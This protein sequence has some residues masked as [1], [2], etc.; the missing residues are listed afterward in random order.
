MGQQV[1]AEV[2]WTDGER[3]VSTG[4]SGN[5]MM[6]DADRTRN[7]APGP[8]ELVLIAL[9]ACTASDVLSILRKKR[10]S[11]NS[12][13][14]RAEAQRASQP[15]TIYT[16]INLIYSVDKEVNKKAME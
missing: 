3:F 11:F 2:Q 4:S 6:P 7:T 12:L 5:A 13:K 1:K 14:V 9:C 15:P 8:M 16:H 10:E